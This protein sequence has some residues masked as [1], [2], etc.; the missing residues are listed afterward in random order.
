MNV[1]AKRTTGLIHAL[2]TA[3]LLGALALPFASQAYAGEPTNSVD[4]LQ[5]RVDATK[6]EVDRTTAEYN[7]AT[8]R[9]TTARTA[10]DAARAEVARL[11]EQIA[12]SQATIKRVGSQLAG[13]KERSADAMRMQYLLESGGFNLTELIFSSESLTG[14]LSSLTYLD[15]FQELNS[16]Q[17]AK[18]T[19]MKTEYEAALATMESAKKE[20]DDHR[21]RAEAEEA[22]AVEQETRAKEAL[23]AAQDARVKAQEEAEAEIERRASELDLAGALGSGV[24][25]RVSRDEFIQEWTERINAYLAGSP[26]DGCGAVMAEAAWDYGVDP[27]WS[28]AIACIESGK[29]R[30]VPYNTSNNAW[31]W[32]AD[33]T[34][35]RTFSSFQEGARLHIEYLARYYGYTIT[36]EHAAKYCPPGDAWYDAVA[37]EMQNV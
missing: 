2:F 11:E 15:H 23:A 17:I 19:A 26:M 13:Q 31:G 16:A 33:A 24:N 12:E 7:E 35:F 9:A 20:A 3:L 10:A 36:R 37:K 25:W 34:H 8:G 22:V 30:A 29:G 1:A 14:F 18:Y 5:E 21:A 6:A 27:R 28:P 4:M 32:F